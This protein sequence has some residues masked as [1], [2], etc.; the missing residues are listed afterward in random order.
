MRQSQEVMDRLAR[1]RRWTRQDAQIALAALQASGL[2]LATFA[3][4]H[5]IKAQRLYGWRRVLDVARAPVR[6]VEV[7]RHTREAAA[8]RRYE[9]RLAEG[10][11]IRLGGPI[12]ADDLRALVRVLRERGPC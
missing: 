5:G 3:H 7:Q 6:F 8:T 12:D 9:V 2:P 11:R 10:D 4:Q 1:R